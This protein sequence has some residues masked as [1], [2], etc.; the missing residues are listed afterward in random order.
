MFVINRKQKEYCYKELCGNLTT[1][2]VWDNILH[3]SLTCFADKS[4]DQN[5]GI[6]FKIIMSGF[7]VKLIGAADHKDAKGLVILIIFLV[8][9]TVLHL[10]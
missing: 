10:T 4:K 8:S 1:H 6:L 3:F 9:L 5:I 7:L 2:Y